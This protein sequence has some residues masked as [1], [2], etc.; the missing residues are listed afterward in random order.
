MTKPTKKSPANKKPCEF[1]KIVRKGDC[2]AGKYNIV[3]EHKKGIFGRYDLEGP[4]KED[5][6]GLV[7]EMPYNE[8]AE[9]PDVKYCPFCGRRLGVENG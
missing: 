9:V 4:A 1:C 6:F 3:V 7:A 8:F 5:Y 2:Y